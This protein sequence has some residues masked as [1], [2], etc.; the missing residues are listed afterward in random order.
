MPLLQKYY[1]VLQKY[2]FYITEYCRLLYAEIYKGRK[3]KFSPF[4]VLI[5][6]VLVEKLGAFFMK[7]RRK[8]VG[9]QEVFLKA[10]RGLLKWR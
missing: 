2:Y 8:A 9:K 4:I 3:P 7:R 1:K 5:L 6:T 10:L